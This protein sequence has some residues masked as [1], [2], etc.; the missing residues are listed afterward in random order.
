MKINIHIKDEKLINSPFKGFEDGWYLARCRSLKKRSLPQNSWFHAVL[1]DILEGL[2]EKGFN[3]VKTET[4]A[5]NV[6][7]ALFFKKTISNGI[8]DIEIIEDT[9]DTS[10][11]DFAERAEDIIIWANEYLG[12]DIAPPAQQT[13]MAI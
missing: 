1:P 2:R 8:E 5:K 11:L 12:L 13:L 7:K 10:K 9:S 6:V 4:D 3:E